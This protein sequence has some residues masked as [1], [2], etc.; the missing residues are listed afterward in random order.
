MA[1]G[2]I[3]RVM[4]RSSTLLN[5]EERQKVSRLGRGHPER[6]E[7]SPADARD[8]R[9]WQGILRRLRGF[10]MTLKLITPAAAA[11][12]ALVR[13]DHRV[14]LVAIAVAVEAVAAEV[15]A[16]VAIAVHVHA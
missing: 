9:F 7:G 8:S 14:P 1:R 13:R 3:F 11:P 12:V 2:R 16:A 6:S 4:V 10:R 15:A 5:A